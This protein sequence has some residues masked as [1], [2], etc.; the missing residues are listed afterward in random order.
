MILVLIFILI[1]VLLILI[2]LLIVFLLILLLLLLLFLKFLEFFLHELVIEF[3]VRVLLFQLHRTLVRLERL[4]PGLNRLLWV[5]FLGL[6][7]DP[8]LGVAQ[9]VKGRLLQ[10]DPA[11]FERLLEGGRGLRIRLLFVGGGA[12]VVL[13]FGFFGILFGRAFVL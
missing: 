13:Q 3:G 8:V 2:F 10:V 7:A 5:G 12:E 6:L 11:G 4:L 9:V 1:L